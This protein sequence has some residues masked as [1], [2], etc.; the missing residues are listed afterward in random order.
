[1]ITMLL[2]RMC[3]TDAVASSRRDQCR[4]AVGVRACHKTPKIYCD[5]RTVPLSHSVLGGKDELACLTGLALE[6]VGQVEM[7]IVCLGRVNHGGTLGRIR[8]VQLG[9]TETITG[10]ADV[11]AASGRVAHVTRA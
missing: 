11:V 5:K 2:V 8:D 10:M 4:A 1:M 9:H 6:R 3:L 7:G